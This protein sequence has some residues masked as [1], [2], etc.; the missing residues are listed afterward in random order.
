MD[1]KL[2]QKTCDNGEVSCCQCRFY[3]AG[4]ESVGIFAGCIHPI[5]YD[6]DDCLIE[7]VN[8]L[9]IDCQKNPVH[10]ILFLKKQ[11][12]AI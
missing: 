12:V 4:D 6:E 1:I 3:D 5:L 11:S 10:C 8:D 7:D 2:C 9:I